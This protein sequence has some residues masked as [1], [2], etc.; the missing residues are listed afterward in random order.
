MPDPSPR[1]TPPTAAGRYLL[2][3]RCLLVVGAFA[4][5]DDDKVSGHSDATGD[6][7][8]TSDSAP[9]TEDSAPDSAD[10]A[11]DTGP[12]PD[13]CTP[14]SEAA[15]TLCADR[16]W[17]QELD[18]TSAAELAAAIADMPA[19]LKD[20]DL[21]DDGAR[22]AQLQWAV[23]AANALSAP[24]VTV[25]LPGG[26][27]DFTGLDEAHTSV[28]DGDFYQEPLRPKLFVRRNDLTLRDAGTGVEPVL[29]ATGPGADGEHHGR[30]YVLLDSSFTRLTVRG[31]VFRG[32]ATSATFEDPAYT[33]HEN[34]TSLYFPFQWGAVMVGLN[35]GGNLM[36]VEDCRFERVNGN[37]ISAVGA[38][39]VTGSTF[40]G[41]LPD[42]AEADPD[43]ASE[44]LLAAII[45]DVGTSPGMDFHAGV[46]R[47]YAYGPTVVQDSAFTGF[48]QGV[49]MA[50]DG[51]P[52]EI[53]GNTFTSIYDHALYI[54]GDAGGGVVEGNRFEGSGN[55]AVKFAAN[56]TEADPERSLAGLHDGFIQDNQFAQIRNGSLFFSG[57]RNT[58]SGNTVAAYDPSADPTGWF[59]PYYRE[60]HHYPDAFLITESGQAGWSNHI[61]LNLFQDNTA[62]EGQ[63]TLLLQQRTT[64]TDRSISGN[65]VSGE[66]QTVYFHHLVPC[67]T[68]PAPCSNF[69]PTIT[70]EDGATLVVGAPEDCADC[71]P[72][73]TR[74]ITELP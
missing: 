64:V 13:D 65:T 24:T 53:S 47:A 54:F 23:A 71:S 6:S 33:L 9:D 66:G 72:S 10:S 22:A 14:S 55:G 61:A 74:Y 18:A 35:G 62:E 20:E 19:A 15:V 38:L 30:V 45:A 27:Y 70:A 68:Y 31:L 17:A 28:P 37:A 44:A 11:P 7:D 4:C 60:G 26:T 21:T 32:D 25:L 40:E 34:A 29:T 57:V 1:R 56:T 46:R 16:F 51:Y 52:L 5:R 8:S 63:F 67:D 58:I 43:E 59:D 3:A 12:P 42:P 2:A 49:L 50:A 39:T 41:A 69:E 48:V 73:D 36:T